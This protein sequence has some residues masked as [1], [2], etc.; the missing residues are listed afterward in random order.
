MARSE[1]FNLRLTGDELA[2]LRAAAKVAA[3]GSL[4]DFIRSA[5]IERANEIHVEQAVR[6]QQE[7]TAKGASHA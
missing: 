5:A 3:D 1:Q 6:R 7:L 2:S 4:A